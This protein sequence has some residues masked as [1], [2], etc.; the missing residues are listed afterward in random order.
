M[1]QSPVL[2]G[3][4][5]LSTKEFCQYRHPDYAIKTVQAQIKLIQAQL[6]PIT[7]ICIAECKTA[8]AQPFFYP[9]QALCI[10]ITNLNHE[11]AERLMARCDVCIQ[12]PKAVRNL[13]SMQG[14]I[15]V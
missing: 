5:L 15:V 10:C 8:N 4:F 7:D 14:L 9:F 2:Q 6:A 11:S 13:G 3:N 12:E 1:S